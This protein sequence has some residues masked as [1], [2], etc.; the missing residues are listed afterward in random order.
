M[1]KEKFSDDELEMLT[2]EEREGLL[3]EDLVDDEPGDEVDEPEIKE[4]AADKTAEVDPPAT[5][6]VAAAPQSFPTFTAPADAKEKLAEIERKRDELAQK[7]DEGELTTIEFRQQDKALAAEERSLNEQVFKATLS[8]EANAASW[9]DN[10]VRP[11]LDQNPQYAPGTPLYRA[12]DEQLK[13]L[14]T[15]ALLDGKSQ[16]DPSLLET[17]HAELAKAMGVPATP[18]PAPSEQQKRELPPTLGG[19]PAASITDADTDGGKFAYLDRLAEKDR[20][21]FEDALA[22]LS[23]DDRDAYLA[24]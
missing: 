22:K 6:K 5:T 14:Q 16:Y 8:A 21:A 2:D 11:F 3:D 23:D 4:P 1:P 12:L 9:V 7:V 18:K 24:A 10:A 15:Q 13:A 20:L 17:A 19:V